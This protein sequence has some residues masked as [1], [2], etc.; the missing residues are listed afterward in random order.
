MKKLKCL[1]ELDFD[2]IAEHEH[3]SY[4]SA[5]HTNVVM[6]GDYM[7]RF[8]EEFQ[9]NDT[10]ADVDILMGATDDEGNKKKKISN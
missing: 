7:S 5:N 9:E 10:L 3:H 1:E 8:H 2:L 6:T 4:T